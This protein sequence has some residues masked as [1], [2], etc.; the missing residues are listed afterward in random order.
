VNAPRCLVLGGSG[1][2]GRAVCDALAADGARVA[3][4]YHAG[5]GAARALAAALPGAV[6]LSLDLTR[7]DA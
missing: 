7:V 2:L 3:F 5:E 1:A 6:P 4:T